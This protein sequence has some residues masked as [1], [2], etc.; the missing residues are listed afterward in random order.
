MITGSP[1]LYL[2]RGLAAG[3]PPEL[4][5]RFIQRAD[6]TERHGLRSVLTLNHLAYQTG[7]DHF[8]LRDVIG[9]DIDPYEEFLLHGKRQISSP[10][11]PIRVV[12]KWILAHI[13]GRVSCHPASYAYERNKS[14]AQCA[15]RHLG[16]SWL[17]K[18]DVHEFFASI[19]ESRIFQVFTELGYGG[20]VSFEMARICT[21]PGIG[22]RHQITAREST[23]ITHYAAIKKYQTPA[24]LG[25]L[26]QGSP[27]SGA[28]ANLVMRAI[29]IKLAE[30]VKGTGIVYTRYA[31][32]IVF[33]TPGSFSR[34]E[35]SELIRMADNML[36][37]N[38]FL[39]HEKKPR[40]YRPALAKSFSACWSTATGSG[41]QSTRET[42]YLMTS[43][44]PNCLAFLR[45]PSTAVS[46][47]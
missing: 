4:L 24:G 35:A 10:R 31:D 17:V 9:R 45:M 34:R 11:P 23:P 37:R 46:L 27:T 22:A 28:L 6:A 2:R 29:D 5:E 41:F 43:V 20:L 13:V 38:G 16:A 47:P 30:A 15:R 26:P 40:S 32:D 14:I 44:V 42:D 7:A 21:R 1:H 25:F 8:Y 12:Q 36:G 39:R 3:R 19:D 33:S 18:L